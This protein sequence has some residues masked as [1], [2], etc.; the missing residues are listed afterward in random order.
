MTEFK[1]EYDP[2]SISK[3][4]IY[5]KENKWFGWYWNELNS[6][7]SLELAEAQLQEFKKFPKYYGI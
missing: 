6:F 5:R 2:A 4:K 3:Y 7:E 1:I